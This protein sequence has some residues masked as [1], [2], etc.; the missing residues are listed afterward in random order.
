LSQL[1]LSF[2]K[3][4]VTAPHYN[5][6][7]TNQK[8]QKQI[9]VQANAACLIDV[10]QF[11]FVSVMQ[12]KIFRLI[13]TDLFCWVPLSIMA[14]YFFSNPAIGQGSNHAFNDFSNIATTVLLPINSALNPIL[15]SNALDKIYHKVRQKMTNLPKR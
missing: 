12:R 2:S 4:N 9:I 3:R 13:V 6:K 1:I 5:N 10:T 11:F 7:A 8:Q 15:Y 14:F